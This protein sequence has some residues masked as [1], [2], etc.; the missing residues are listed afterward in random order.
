[1]ASHETS[2][3]LQGKKPIG[4]GETIDELPVD[5]RS[6]RRVLRDRRIGWEKWCTPEVRYSTSAR[7]ILKSEA[8]IWKDD[9]AQLMAY[10]LVRSYMRE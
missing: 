6:A 1:L 4:G 8:A 7:Q 2:E 10:A 5:G 9:P 3:R